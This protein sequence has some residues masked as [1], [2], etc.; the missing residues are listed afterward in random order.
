[1]A[2]GLIQGIRDAPTTFRVM[3]DD[4]SV[5]EFSFDQKLY[6]A[7]DGGYLD[8]IVRVV[9]PV[10]S[11]S[12]VLAGCELYIT[13]PESGDTIPTP[14]Y[15]GGDR[16]ELLRTIQEIVEANAIPEL[17]KKDEPI[18]PIFEKA[19][20]ELDLLAREAARVMIGAWGRVPI[21]VMLDLQ[22]NFHGKVLNEMIHLN[23]TPACQQPPS[24]P[25]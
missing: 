7:K 21:T 24:S 25:P 12:L 9:S 8:A 5:F 10:M 6:N 1:M 2:E 13:A 14:T 22:Q 3:R 16:A 23:Q 19:G 17:E 11:G 20:A 18:D 15:W 4:P